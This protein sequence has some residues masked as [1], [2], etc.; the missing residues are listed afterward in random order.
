MTVTY[1]G[2]KNTNREVETSPSLHR[3]G[4]TIQAPFKNNMIETSMCAA[5]KPKS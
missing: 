2:R 1:L 4:Q 5:K 3:D